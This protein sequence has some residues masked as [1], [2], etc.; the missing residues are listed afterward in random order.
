MTAITI[1][2]FDILVSASNQA[3]WWTPCAVDLLGNEYFACCAA[4]KIGNIGG[5]HYVAIIKRDKSGAYTIGYC[6]DKNGLIAQ[7]VNDAGHNNPSITIDV[8]GYIHGASSM[9]TS[10]WRYFKSKYPYDIQSMVEQSIVL[11]D[12]GF[13]YTYPILTSD[14]GGNVY[15][16][17]RGGAT[18]NEF[19]RAGLLYKYSRDTALWERLMIIANEGNRSFYPDDLRVNADLSANI[20]WERGPNGAGTLRHEPAW[21]KVD[22]A[23]G[24]TA[25]D[26]TVLHTPIDVGNGGAHC[27]QPLVAGET[28]AANDTPEVVTSPGVQTAKFVYDGGVVKNI[29]YRYRPQRDSASST[30]GGFDV[31]LATYVSGTGWTYETILPLDVDG[32]ST[33]AALSA[34][35][36][37]AETRLYFSIEKIGTT[38]TTA[39]L[40]MARQKSGGGWEY[41]VIGPNYTAPLRMM[42]IKETS[43]DMLY[44]TAPGEQKLMRY[45]V[46]QVLTD[47]SIY[48]T[49]ELLISSLT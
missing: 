25:P 23:G 48:A 1:Q 31:K 41:V 46:P 9:H 39:Q 27:Y 28:Y 19:D 33:S 24:L 47:S 22:T 8:D 4:P 34:T 32:I 42:A 26:G 3:G 37:G 20:L 40:V 17:A 11:P 2:Q 18:A 30:F 16:L 43:G 12:S 6:I 35:V 15:I 21:I 45:F 38:K 44:V 10:S 49:P 13:Q 29:L 7:Y 5:S 36:W 14:S